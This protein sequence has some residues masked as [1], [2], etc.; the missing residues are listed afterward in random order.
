MDKIFKGEGRCET[1]KV[2]NF[3]GLFI[4]HVSLYV[5]SGGVSVFAAINGILSHNLKN[6]NLLKGMFCFLTYFF[7]HCIS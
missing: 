2:R 4:D 5:Y 7:S 1:K 6:R 3:Q